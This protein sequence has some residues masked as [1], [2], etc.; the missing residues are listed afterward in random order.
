[1]SQYPQIAYPLCNWILVNYNRDRSPNFSL[2]ADSS[3]PQL[4]TSYW[5]CCKS[6][7]R[8]RSLCDGRPYCCCWIV[9][10]V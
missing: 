5:D 10:R 7:D 9:V 2:F 6:W 1:M 8:Q 4:Q 3:L